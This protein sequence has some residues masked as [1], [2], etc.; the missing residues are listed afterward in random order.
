MIKAKTSLFARTI[1]GAGCLSILLTSG[2]LAAPLSAQ[3]EGVQAEAATTEAAAAAATGETATATAASTADAVIAKAQSLKGKVSYKWGVNDA[4]NLIFDCS[5]FT[6]YVFASQGIS[7]KWGSKAQSKQGTYVSQSQLKK[8]DLVF[9]S[10]GQSGVIDHVGIYI[11][12]GKFIHNTIGGSVNGVTI[13]DL[14]AASYK[15]RYITA[16]RVI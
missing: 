4:T 5:S 8:G 3:A 14:N 9:L 6:K 10:V 13:G 16:R 7:L 15:K 11:G 12:G 2:L 1:V